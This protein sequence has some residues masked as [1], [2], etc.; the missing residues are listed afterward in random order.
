MTNTAAAL[1]SKVKDVTGALRAGHG[2]PAAASEQPDAPSL[3]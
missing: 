1:R 3:R 2:K